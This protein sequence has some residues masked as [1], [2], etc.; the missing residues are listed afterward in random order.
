MSP[1]RPLWHLLLTVFQIAALVAFLMVGAEHS[2][3]GASHTEN[4]TIAAVAPMEAQ[5][6]EQIGTGTDRATLLGDESTIGPCDLCCCH[7][8]FVRW[9]SYAVTVTWKPERRLAGLRAVAFDSLHPET[10]PEPPRR[11]A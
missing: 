10:L 5:E 11:F 2:N 7:A 4:A 8:P 1:T 3:A 6:A 9:A